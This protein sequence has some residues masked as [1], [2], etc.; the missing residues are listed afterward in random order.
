M[1]SV[2]SRLSLA[3]LSVPYS[4]AHV[5]G[6]RI[7]HA[8]L[9]R[10]ALGHAPAPALLQVAHHRLC[11]GRGTPALGPRARRCSTRVEAVALRYTPNRAR[12][13]PDHAW[14]GPLRPVA[15]AQD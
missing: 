1:F 13:H 8:V 5:H 4:Q 3:R 15:Q 2:R 7:T 11:V 10:E 14:K 9:L 6:I 12:A